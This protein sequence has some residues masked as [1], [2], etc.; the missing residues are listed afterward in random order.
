MNITLE[1]SNRLL[2][3]LSYQE[4]LSL[5]FTYHSLNY[6]GPSA[7]A[8][9]NG[10]LEKASIQTGFTYSGGKLLIEAFPAPDMGCTLLFTKL[11][12]GPKYRLRRQS[13]SPYIFEFSSAGSMMSA[14]ELLS[15]KKICD[16]TLY[17]IG[18]KYRVLLRHTNGK[19]MT[20]AL[21]EF[22]RPL[23]SSASVAAYT[24]EHGILLCKNASTTIGGKLIH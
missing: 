9:I 18:E 2:I 19:K 20:A 14:M 16:G 13:A 11:S 10:L 24:A 22:G 6:S 8:A 4:L 5:G 15:Q 1:D 7:K 23:G 17:K 12:A 3:T 21:S